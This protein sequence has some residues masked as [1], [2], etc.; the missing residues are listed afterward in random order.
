MSLFSQQPP[1]DFNGVE[2]GQPLTEAQVE[3]LKERLRKLA[4]ESR[5]IKFVPLEPEDLEFGE[6]PE[7]KQ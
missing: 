5:A 4:E 7:F 3:A 6:L 2:V 1:F